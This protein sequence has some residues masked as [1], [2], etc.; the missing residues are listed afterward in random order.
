M[1]KLLQVSQLLTALDIVHADLKPDNILVDFDGNKIRNLKVIDFGSAFLFS[2]ATTIS[3][4]TPE[5]LAPEVLQYIDKR[6]SIGK[7]GA[8]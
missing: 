8:K 4:S 5:Y 2:D 6:H 7:E 3:M 1:T